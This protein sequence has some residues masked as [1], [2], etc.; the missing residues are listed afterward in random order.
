MLCLEMPETMMLRKVIE[1][2]YG[3]PMLSLTHAD[4]AKHRKDME[5][6]PFFMG[7]KV[8]DLES[9]EKA[10]RQA[11]KRHSLR[12]M[13]F[14]NLNF[15]VRSVQ[16]QVNELGLVTKRLKELAVDLNIPIILIAQPT[17]I[18][19]IGDAENDDERCERQRIDRA[20]TVMSTATG[21]PA[22][23]FKEKSSLRH[24]Y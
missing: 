7:S 18:G 14:D 6:L 22:G 15:F 12:L 17:K 10:V 2:R 23:W 4:V 21:R 19:V 5:Q 11:V 13:A 3:I 1:H 8:K 9:M 16:N 24:Y 20:R